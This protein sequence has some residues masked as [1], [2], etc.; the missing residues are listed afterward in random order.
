MKLTRT[1]HP[2]GQGGFYTETLE[3][4][5]EKIN[6]VYDCGGNNKT[7][8][9]EYLKPQNNNVFT[10]IDKDIDIDAVFISHFHVDHINGLKYLLDKYKVKR[11][12]LPQLEEDEKFELLLYNLMFSEEK[13]KDAF[14]DFVMNLINFNGEKIKIKITRILHDD[15]KSKVNADLNTDFDCL[16]IK[17]DENIKEKIK[18]GTKISF[19]NK[20]LFIPYNPPY[21][22]SHQKG[23]DSFCAYFKNKL[24]LK[25]I[26]IKDLPDFYKNNEKEC[27]KTY[28]NYFKN[29]SHN[30]YSMTLFSGM[31]DVLPIV[32]PSNDF[33]NNPIILQN[34]NCLYMGDFEDDNNLSIYGKIKQF[35]MPFWENIATVQVPHH[36][37]RRN[38]FPDLYDNPSYGIV[39]VGEKNQFHLPNM[40]TLV[41]IK[42][43]KCLPI[44]VT[45]TSTT[46]RVF[47]FDLNNQNGTNGSFELS[48]PVD[49]NQNVSTIMKIKE[50]E[51]VK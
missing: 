8:M 15:D 38:I 1:I 6:V 42:E 35:Y 16:D 11:L 48:A 30:R 43:K 25:K 24:R 19:Q 51:I 10:N 50:D 26:S 2:I 49:G 9:E 21:V 34:P 7:F 45:E 14:I 20:W 32:K 33:W 31:S 29:T 39:S 44:I 5:G 37:S 46:K 41:E 27:K 3:E 23:K 22:P 18:V 12:F 36:G 40:D 4:D 13:D 17:K 47:L 28:N